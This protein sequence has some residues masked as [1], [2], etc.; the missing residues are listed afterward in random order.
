VV[1]DSV[2]LTAVPVCRHRG[3]LILWC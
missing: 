1:T 3:P 2:A